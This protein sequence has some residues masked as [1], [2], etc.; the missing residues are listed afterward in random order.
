[1]TSLHIRAEAATLGAVLHEPQLLEQL[2]GQ[3][4]PGVWE[5]PWHA[6]VWAAMSRL[7]ARGQAATPQA[8]AAEVARDPDVHDA[9]TAAVRVAELM[10]AAPRPGHVAYYARMV[11][12]ASRRR[13]LMDIGRRLAQAATS[14]GGAEAVAQAAA[15]REALTPVREA[16]YGPPP[17]RVTPHT[18]AE[19]RQAQLDA[20]LAHADDVRARA[21]AAV[22]PERSG[23][24][25]ELA[26]LLRRV[27]AY[28]MELQWRPLPN[29]PDQQHV[30]A[31][32]LAARSAQRRH[33][34]RHAAE[35]NATAEATQPGAAGRTFEAGTVDA[36]TEAPASAVAE[37]E[38]AR[39]TA[40]RQMLAAIAAAPATGLAAAKALTRDQWA[41][42]WR[43][44]IATL[45]AGLHA[46]GEP[47]DPLTLEWA[48]RQAGI[49]ADQPTGEQ[50]P[51]AELADTL[52]GSYLDAASHAREIGDTASRITVAQAA[53]QVLTAA[54]DPTQ[55]VT[56]TMDQLDTALARVAPDQHAEP[57]PAHGD[58]PQHGDQ[59]PTAHESGSGVVPD[60]GTS[61]VSERRAGY[62]ETGAAAPA[63]RATVPTEAHPSDDARGSGSTAV[64]ESRSTEAPERERAEPQAG[65]TAADR[66][67]AGRRRPSAGDPYP[68]LHTT[69]EAQAAHI[70]TLS[71]ETRTIVEQTEARVD[72]AGGRPI[73]ITPTEHA[74]LLQTRGYTAAVAGE[75]AQQAAAV[76]Q[77][78][79]R[80][81]AYGGATKAWPSRPSEAT[82]SG[83][84]EAPEREQPASA[85][86]TRPDQIT[87]DMPVED[88]ARAV[89]GR[90]L[91]KAGESATGRRVV[92]RDQVER[93]LTGHY[94][95]PPE[96]ARAAAD[97]TAQLDADRVGQ[98]EKTRTSEVTKSRT[99]AEPQSR[100]N[101]T[102]TRADVPEQ[103]QPGREAIDIADWNA[104]MM[105]RQRRADG[106]PDQDPAGQP[107]AGR[108]A[109]A[110]A[111]PTAGVRR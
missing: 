14:A 12:D 61:E 19:Q 106:T 82:N 7:R 105:A 66:P 88:M 84:T 6:Q 17:R 83:R 75:V 57:E 5:R 9:A 10:E 86:Q 31:R 21:E 93:V 94:K 69:P 49:V 41:D 99:P 34:R 109:A 36:E 90:I 110:T 33:A 79:G 30:G 58:A 104:R 62:A 47:V 78:T 1:M 65:P 20:L 24:F 74:A 111:Q 101:E 13:T 4:G 107:A 85:A 18:T 91:R 54:D 95:V 70:A 22:E 48:A 73:S 102:D 89:V 46:A 68:A 55:E 40:E 16:H 45:A 50:I 11:G 103:P 23:L 98:H 27:T 42:T 108:D 2:A 80:P 32:E 3:L 92:D 38:Q 29:N 56:A 81:V 71:Q 53:E 64:T 8:V 26:D 52:R 39:E 37:V 59:A 77:R 72:A 63:G 67:R 96:V 43:R 28:V 60:S 97:R 44:D 25:A 76:A 51:A 35:Q 100:T 87:P 15:A